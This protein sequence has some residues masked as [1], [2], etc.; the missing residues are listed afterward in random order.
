VLFVLFFISTPGSAGAPWPARAEEAWKALP[1]REFIDR[2]TP[3]AARLP[4][5][6]PL[7]ADGRDYVTDIFRVREEHERSSVSRVGPLLMLGED[8]APEDAWGVLLLE[9]GKKVS[10]HL[11]SLQHLDQGV[12]LGRY[13]RCGI[14]LSGVE[15][16]SR[17]HLLLVRSGDDVLAIDTASTNGTWRGKTEIQTDALR[18]PDSLQLAKAI[19]IHWRR[20]PPSAPVRRP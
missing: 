12:L 9:Q 14:N 17:V 11:L 1:P 4:H 16:I 3:D 18:D 15:G 19:Q 7:R 6:R 10:R 5:S 20:V 8:V 13:D 2:R